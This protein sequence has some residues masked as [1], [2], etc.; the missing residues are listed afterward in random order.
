[1]QRDKDLKTMMKWVYIFLIWT[2]LCLIS[3]FWVKWEF[4]IGFWLLITGLV[5][6]KYKEKYRL[7]YNRVYGTDY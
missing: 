3:L 5:K 6:L 2:F 1:M 7:W 4:S